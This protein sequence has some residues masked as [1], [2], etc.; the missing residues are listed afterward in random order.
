MNRHFN[1]KLVHAVKLSNQI[2]DQIQTL[3]SRG[4]V[5]LGRLLTFLI[6]VSFQHL[7]LRA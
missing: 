2:L 5:S 4:S 3:A 6:G 1:T 7:P